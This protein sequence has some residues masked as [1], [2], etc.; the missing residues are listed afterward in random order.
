MYLKSSAEFYVYGLLGLC[1][2]SGSAVVIGEGEL[3]LGLK[4]ALY[5]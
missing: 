4:G 1:L 2:G 3:T 5:A